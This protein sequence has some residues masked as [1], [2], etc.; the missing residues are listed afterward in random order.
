MGA[1]ASTAV[2]LYA[3]GQVLDAARLNL[4]NNGIPV[5]SGTATR[6]AAFGGSG[7]KVLAEGQFVYLEDTN[8]LQVYNSSVFVNFTPES[9]SVV[10][11]QTTTSSSFTDLATAGP[12]VTVVTGTSAIVAVSCFALNT[13]GAG[14]TAFLGVDVSGAST[15]AA[16]VDSGI[17]TT[18]WTSN[19]SVA[20]S[21]MFKITGL[22]A[23]SN[24]FKMQYKCD[25]STIN[26]G[27]RYIV[28]IPIA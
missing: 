10:T 19:A 15:I 8:S 14:N 3:S 22:T 24:T 4:T 13:V 12:S 23:G 2:P 20:M 9:A 21:A 17:R 18:F 25:G 7:E 6:D 5:F 1:N 11:N 16:N 28:V 27:N 26:F